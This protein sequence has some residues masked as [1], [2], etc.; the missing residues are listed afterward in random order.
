M[1]HY[2]IVYCFIA[3]E[4]CSDSFLFLAAEVSPVRRLSQ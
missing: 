4:V 2:C 3:H 1:K